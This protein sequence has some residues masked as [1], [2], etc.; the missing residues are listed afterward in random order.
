MHRRFIGLLVWLALFIVAAMV[1]GSLLG[2]IPWNIRRWGAYLVIPAVGYMIT[3][4]ADPITP[5]PL[6]IPLLLLYEG[7]IIVIKRLKR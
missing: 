4:G 2:F 5:L 3:P 1:I 7:S 6:I